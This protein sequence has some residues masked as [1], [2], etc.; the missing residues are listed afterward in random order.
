MSTTATNPVRSQARDS[1][2]ASGPHVHTLAHL[3]WIPAGAMVG[4][5]A[6]FTFGDLL[7][8]PVDLYYAIYFAIVIGFFGYYVRRTGLDLRGWV[9]RRLGWA[10]GV[11]VLGGLA[12][13]Q[14]VL[15]R[16]ETAH[17]SGGML[18]WAIVYRGLLYGSV[19]GLLLFAFPWIVVWRAFGAEGGARSLRLRASGVA[20]AA[21]LLITTTYHLG[22]RD[23]RSSKIV[24]PNVGSTIGAVPTLVTANPVASVIGHAIMHVTSVVHSPGSDLYL[25]PHRGPDGG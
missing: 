3:A 2:A 18:A 23:F 15:A 10:V 4:W 8:L 1:K 21:M 17:L 25:P 22:Y 6:S 19:D 20:F 14:G 7:T 5:L 24:M 13:M 9:S 12:L 11:G 16:P